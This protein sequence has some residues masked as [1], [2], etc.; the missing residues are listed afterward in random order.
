M[1]DSIKTQLVSWDWKSQKVWWKSISSII[2]HLEQWSYTTKNV[3]IDLT[4][5]NLNDYS[6]NC[7]D[8]FEFM[9]H[10]IKTEEADLSYP[11]IVDH[12]WT[13]IDWRHRL[14]KAIMLWKKKIKW[15]MIYDDLWLTDS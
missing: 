3:T 2:N 15:V 11:I 9:L 10:Y 7:P 14:C 5:I 8:L 6:F 4:C 1:L 12:K 13:I